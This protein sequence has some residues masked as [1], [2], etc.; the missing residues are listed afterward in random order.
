M[1]YYPLS[2]AAVAR[3]GEEK[4]RYARREVWKI[5]CGGTHA[6]KAQ[7]QN[8]RACC[9]SV[10]RHTQHVDVNAARAA[11]RKTMVTP[12]CSA[13]GGVTGAARN[14]MKNWRESYAEDVAVI[15]VGSV[16]VSERSRLRS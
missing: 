12:Q 4:E 8:A 10:P 7:P 15:H 6:A 13:K 9:C 1:R 2:A 5:E 3:A 14:V 11:W 16:L